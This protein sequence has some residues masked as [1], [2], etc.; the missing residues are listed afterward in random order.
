LN[1]KIKHRQQKFDD[2][3]LDEEGL[4]DLEQL[5]RDY[6][7]LIKFDADKV[8][9]QRFVLFNID[10]TKAEVSEPTEMINTD[11][12]KIKEFDNIKNKFNKLSPETLEEIKILFG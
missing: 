3:K 10:N 7:E 9:E 4:K 2:G 12:G 11:T 1:L 6:Y 8:Q 5:E